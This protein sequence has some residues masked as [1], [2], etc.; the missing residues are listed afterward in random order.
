VSIGLVPIPDV[1]L[2]LAEVLMAA[3]SACYAAKERG[4]DNVHVYQPDDSAL[5]QRHGEMQ[6]VPRIHDALA[7]GRFCLYQQPIIALGTSS[8][9]VHFTEILL[10]LLAEDGRVVPPGAFIP[11]AERYGLIGAIDRWVVQNALKS[12]SGRL[13]DMGDHCYAINLS[14]QSLGEKGF[15]NF[16]IDEIERSRV[17]ATSV[18]FEV[19]ETAAIAD[20]T[21]ALRFISGLK[22]RGCQFAL[23]DFGSG[24]SSFS[25]LK[26]L[27]V[28]YLKIDGSFVQGMLADPVDDT[29]VEA[30]HRIGA[31]MGI[32]TIAESV[33]NQATLERLRVIGVHHAQGYAIAQPEPLG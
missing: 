4:R 24:L 17:P 25:Y 3:D 7:E 23:D 13:R 10:R 21:D 9:N 27:P 28:D 22:E 29:M 5:A 2:S 20:L 19:T 1:G 12:L 16:V 31:V 6:W 18:C 30:I 32:K 8:D 15:L 33:E 14:G 11:A 26:N